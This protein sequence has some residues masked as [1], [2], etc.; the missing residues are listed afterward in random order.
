[1]RRLD[2]PQLAE[3]NRLISELET[4]QVELERACAAYKTKLVETQAFCAGIVDELEAHISDKSEKWQ[5]SEIGQ[6]YVEWQAQWA[7][8]EFPECDAPSEQAAEI[9]GA[10]DDEPAQ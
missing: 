5:E 1:M 3:K 4:A 7:D 9:L 2:K 6:A 8:V 10:I